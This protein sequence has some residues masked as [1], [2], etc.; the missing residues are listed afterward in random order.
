MLIA[1]HVAHA[2]DC[3]VDARGVEPDSAWPIAGPAKTVTSAMT[4]AA[5]SATAYNG[6]LVMFTKRP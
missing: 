6:R 1:T 2:A 4:E 3:P 5:T